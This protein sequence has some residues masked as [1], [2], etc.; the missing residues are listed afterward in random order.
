MTI[1]ERPLGRSGLSTTPLMLGGNVFGWTADRAASF[2]VL[3]AFADGGGKLIDTADM[4]SNWI[5]GLVGG[6]S[7]TMIGEWQASRRCRDRILIATKVGRGQGEYAGLARTTIVQAVEGSLRRLRTDYIDLYFAHLDDLATPLEETLRAFDD[8]VAAGKVRALGASHYGPERLLEAR[9]LG[10]SLGLARYEVLQPRYNLMAR[11]SFEGPLQQLCVDER[12]GV[13]PFYALAS[14]FLTGKYRSQRDL[15]ERQRGAE[16]EKYLNA[17]GLGVLDALDTVA[18]Q[19]GATQAQ[20][21][22]AWLMAQPGITAP[23]ASATSAV[24]AAEL[25]AAMRLDLDA[26]QLALIGDA[27]APGTAPQ[28]S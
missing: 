3:D 24:Q 6:E 17:F 9:A 19:T 14:G 22:L 20:V 26:V 8:L 18:A 13:V 11:A 2:A 1:T 7:E 4:Y 15:S 21:A 5:P 28:P 25:A 16:V 23:I 27:S 12:I 10:D